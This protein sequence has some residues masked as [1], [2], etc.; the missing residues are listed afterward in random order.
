MLIQGVTLTG[1]YVVDEIPAA[2]SIITDGLLVNLDAGDSASYPGSGTTWT[3]LQGSNDATIDGA[4]YS[5][6]DSGIF[7]FDGVNDVITIP[8][9]ADM[10]AT[11]GGT[12]TLQTWVKVDSYD[13]G[14]G[15]WGKQY[16]ASSA[17][18]GYSLALQ[19]NNVIRL[20]MNGNTVNGGYNSAT[21]AFT[22]G[23]WM[24]LTVVVRFGGGSG[25]PSLVYKDDNS[26]PIISQ[27]NAE[28]G[29]TN[30]NAPFIFA[31]DVQEGTDY[32]DINIGALYVYNRALSTAEIAENFNTTK[33]RYGL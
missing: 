11:V 30:I 7:V 15:I 3:D 13:N 22:L 33:A 16:G 10:R 25:S 6:A 27:A 14:D 24:F 28:N 20:Q 29:I 21:N 18:D 8:D 31:R 2:Q 4:T 19:T 9:S 32:A 17:Y 26:T 12:R 1:T 5:A 23:T